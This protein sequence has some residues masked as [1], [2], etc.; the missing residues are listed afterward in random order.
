[1]FKSVCIVFYKQ[2]LGST[3]TYRAASYEKSVLQQ[4]I[5]MQ[6]YVVTAIYANVCLFQYSN[7]CMIR[8]VVALTKHRTFI[9]FIK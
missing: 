9:I 8:D 2:L 6:L 4:G 7:N 5:L 3:Y 1:M